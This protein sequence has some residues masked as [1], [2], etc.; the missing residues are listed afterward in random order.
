MAVCMKFLVVSM[1]VAQLRHNLLA[2]TTM[3]CS[4]LH[5]FPANDTVSTVLKQALQVTTA[6]ARR[7]TSQD[8]PGVVAQDEIAAFK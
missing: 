1:P 4:W 7:Y 8:W 2:G 6:S 3:S 5:A